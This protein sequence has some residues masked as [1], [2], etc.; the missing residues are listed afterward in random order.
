MAGSAC[1]R[2]V[3]LKQ[4]GAI[5]GT[6]GCSLLL[7]KFPQWGSPLNGRDTAL[8]VHTLS[9]LLQVLTSP[10]VALPACLACGTTGLRVDSPV[11]PHAATITLLA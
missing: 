5:G 8:H 2:R 11:L 9:F 3:T 4:K 6:S 1:S 7:C 10:E